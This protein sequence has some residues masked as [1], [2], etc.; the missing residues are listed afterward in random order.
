LVELW[1]IRSI[2]SRR[3]APASAVSLFPVWRRLWK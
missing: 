2:S 1:P 3:F